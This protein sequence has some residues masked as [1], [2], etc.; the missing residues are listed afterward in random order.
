MCDE[1]RDEQD[2]RWG[3][4]CCHCKEA[5]GRLREACRGCGRRPCREMKETKHGVL[6]T[7]TK[8]ART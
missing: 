2:Y 5:N 1:L 8:E 3:W 6:R 4:K 7:K